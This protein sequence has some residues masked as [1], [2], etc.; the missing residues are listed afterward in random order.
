M[1]KE[2]GMRTQGTG[3]LIE[4]LFFYTSRLRLQSV[5]EQKVMSNERTMN[6]EG[7]RLSRER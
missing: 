2:M 4:W 6:R 1:Q 3:C 7:K 5:E